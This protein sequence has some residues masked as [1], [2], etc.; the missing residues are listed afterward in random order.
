MLALELFCIGRSSAPF[1]CV[2]ACACACFI[3]VLLAFHVCFLF[4]I[5]FFFL[6]R[7]SSF[8]W[9]IKRTIVDALACASNPFS[10]NFIFFSSF[11]N[12]NDHDLD[13]LTCFMQILLIWLFTH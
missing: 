8:G 6:V 11:R 7:F 13:G 9:M 2:C 5:S 10:W 3:F 12:F 4:Y 1:V